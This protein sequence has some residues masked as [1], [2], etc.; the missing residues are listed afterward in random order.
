MFSNLS[1]SWGVFFFGELRYFNEI[2]LCVLW[3]NVI[4][5]KVDNDRKMGKKWQWNGNLKKDYRNDAVVRLNIWIDWYAKNLNLKKQ[6][7][8]SEFC[9]T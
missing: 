9:L 2:L 1:Q 8:F 6:G 4:W 3:I 7:G 5:K